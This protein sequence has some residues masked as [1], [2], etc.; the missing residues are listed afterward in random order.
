M[1]GRFIFN[2]ILSITITKLGLDE[3]QGAYQT[4]SSRRQLSKHF[5]TSFQSHTQYSAYHQRFLSLCILPH[6]RTSPLVYYWFPMTIARSIGYFNRCF[7]SFSSSFSWYLLAIKQKQN[8][9]P[10]PDPFGQTY[11]VHDPRN[12]DDRNHFHLPLHIRHSSCKLP[13]DPSQSTIMIGPGTVVAPFRG[14]IQERAA[15]ITNGEKIG[16]TLLFFGCRRKD[17]D[18]LYC[19]EFKVRQYNYAQGIST[20]TLF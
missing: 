15:Q 10:S 2:Y 17:E 5:T 12:K 13:S 6:V 19:S 18:F 14:F 16:I 7:E 11:W 9:K 3:I 4:A 8:N 20:L 1:G